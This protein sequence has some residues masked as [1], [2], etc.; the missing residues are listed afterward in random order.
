MTIAEAAV[1]DL[2]AVRELAQRWGD[3]WNAH[4]ADAVAA[5]C[6]PDLVYD[7][8]AL[9][10]TV[11]GRE[12]IRRFVAR[13]GA[14]YPDHRF[15]LVGVYA[16]VDRRAVLVAWRFTGTRAGTGQ[17]VEFHGDDRLDLGEDG[18]IA[19]YRCL[20]DHDLVLRQLGASTAS[21]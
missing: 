4:D 8:P 18:L 2:Q 10:D 5:L 21:A 14:A 12:A 11:H 9:G 6:A 17:R 3:A 1:T 13:M 16:D 15:H 19:A 20:Y 7:E